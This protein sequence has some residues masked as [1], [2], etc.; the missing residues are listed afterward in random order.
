MVCRRSD[1]VIHRNR[2]SLELA[3]LQRLVGMGFDDLKATL[4]GTL[5]WIAINSCRLRRKAS[6][7]SVDSLS[8]VDDKLIACVSQLKSFSS[9]RVIELERENPER[10]ASVLIDLDT[11]DLHGKRNRYDGDWGKTVR[12]A[13]VCD[14]I[15]Y[16]TLESDSTIIYRLGFPGGV[17]LTPLY[18]SC[19]VK[20]MFVY[21]KYLLVQPFETRQIFAID[22]DSTA[23]A[24]STK[25]IH[26][27]IKIQDVDMVG[28]SSPSMMLLYFAHGASHKEK[29]CLQDSRETEPSHEFDSRGA[30]AARFIPGTKGYVGAMLLRE[31]AMAK[32]AVMEMRV[33]GQILTETQLFGPYRD[34]FFCGTRDWMLHVLAEKPY[35]KDGRVIF[36][37]DDG[38]GYHA[39]EVLMLSLQ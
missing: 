6:G 9:L 20:D 37:D 16:Y 19:S 10:V 5:P 1:R 14:S 25:I 12:R 36:G 18:P 8:K 34:V 35:S 28:S 13:C 39:G 30:T 27:I 29:I 26:K 2:I 23:P 7:I 17:I 3:Y 4:W 15:L 33:S 22:V 24:F 21:D 32:I 31:D 38:R 11:E